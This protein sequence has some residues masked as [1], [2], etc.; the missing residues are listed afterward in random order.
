MATSFQRES[1]TVYEFPVRGR[2]AIANRQREEAEQAAS[3]PRVSFG[4]GWYH[5]EAMEA[6]SARKN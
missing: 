5:D 6:E 3:L 2:F 4:S 1:A